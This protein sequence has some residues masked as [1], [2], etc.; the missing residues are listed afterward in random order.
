M[1][2]ERVEGHVAH[3]MRFVAL[4]SCTG[5]MVASTSDA[6]DLA[7]FLVAWTQLDGDAG[8]VSTFESRGAASSW[9]TLLPPPLPTW[10]AA[11]C[12][13]TDDEDVIVLEE[14]TPVFPVFALLRQSGGQL[15]ADSNSSLIPRLVNTIKALNGEVVVVRMLPSIGSAEE[16]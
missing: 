10:A 2:V 1:E 6:V 4:R 7:R 16:G 13:V 12:S 15:A 14:D 11:P 3:P 9:V 8:L 5:S